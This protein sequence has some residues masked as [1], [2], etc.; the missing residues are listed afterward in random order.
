MPAVL[1]ARLGVGVKHRTGVAVVAP[2]AGPTLGAGDAP[3]G[4]CV[5]GP[6][7]SAV[8]MMQ[9]TGEAPGEPTAV[10]A[11]SV[12]TPVGTGDAVESVV[13]SASGRTGAEAGRNAMLR[14]VN[15]MKMES[16]ASLDS[17]CMIYPVICT[18]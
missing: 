9:G 15:A 7:G 3:S 11:F 2:P 18:G 4:G 5:V 12:S 8:G 14:T 1:A 10:G 16:G 6:A 17:V 13:C